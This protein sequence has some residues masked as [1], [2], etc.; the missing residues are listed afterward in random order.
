MLA[1]IYRSAAVLDSRELFSIAEVGKVKFANTE[2]SR[3]LNSRDV[4]LAIDRELS[5]A[6]LPVERAVRLS[7]EP[8]VLLG[9]LLRLNQAS[10]RLQPLSF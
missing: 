4:R 7:D 9:H 5:V 6:K 2:R 3:G 10:Q 1:S 8:L